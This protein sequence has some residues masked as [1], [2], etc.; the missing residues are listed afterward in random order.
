[1]PESEREIEREREGDRAGQTA[2]EQLPLRRRDKLTLLLVQGRSA[3]RMQDEVQQHRQAGRQTGAGGGSHESQPL[4]A[5][6]ATAR[7][8]SFIPRL[9]HA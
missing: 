4:G 2:G 1:M 9:A 3:K 5:D 6:S 8:F 7:R